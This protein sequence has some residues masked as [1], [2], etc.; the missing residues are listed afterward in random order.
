VKKAQP[1]IDNLHRMVSWLDM[2]KFSAVHHLRLGSFLRAMEEIVA[3]VNPEL[4]SDYRSFCKEIGELL[5]GELKAISC[6][7][8]ASAAARFAEDVAL[9]S[10]EGIKIRATEL[11]NGISSEMTDQLF[12]WIPPERAKFFNET[13]KTFGKDVASNFPSALSEIR[14]AG[15]CYSTGASTACVFHLMR[16]MEI[17]LRAV[18]ASLELPFDPNVS[19]GSILKEWGHDQ[20][21][22]N[23]T[24]N[25][26]LMLDL[27]F[28][29]NARATVSSVKDAWRNATMHFDRSYNESEAL[30]IITAVRGFMK[31]VAEK[32]DEKGQTS[33]FS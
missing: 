13:E 11:R 23:P 10:K 26:R 20:I 12:L 4:E 14:E 27:P 5:E 8:S 33:I 24:A 31:C 9:L 3:N 15:N 18:Y 28:Y 7:Y 22:S 17:G 21:K 25:A 16:V 2:L 30:E 32:I 1:W 6:R 29:Q 19:W